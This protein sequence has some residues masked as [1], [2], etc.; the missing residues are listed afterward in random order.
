MTK[1]NRNKISQKFIWLV[2]F[3]LFGLLFIFKLPALAQDSIT[4]LNQ[5]ILDRKQTLSDLQ[6]Q[7]NAYQQ[8]IDQKIGEAKTLSN[9]LAIITNEVAKIELDIQASDQSIQTANLEIQSINIQIK[10]TENKIEIQ[11]QE[12]EKF[13]N[14]IYKNDQVSYLEILLAND[15]L[16]DFF[17]Y[18]KSTQQIQGSLK[19]TYDQ[20]KI[21]KT[22]LNGQLVDLEAKKVEE[23]NLRDQLLTQKSQLSEKS[24]AQVV[25]I[26]QTKMSQKQYEQYAYQLKLQQQQANSDITTL[27]KKIRAEAD[28]LKNLGSSSLDWPVNPA[29]G[30]TTY[31]HDPD[32]PFRYLFEHPGLDIRAAQGTSLKSPADAY[33]GKI[34][35]RGDT[36]YAYVLLIHADGIST[37]YG[38]ISKP[39]V[40]EGQY[41]KRGQA[42]A[43]SGGAPGSIGAGPLTTGPHL[44]LEVRVNGIPINPLKYLPTI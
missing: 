31:F 22:I 37:V 33:V 17:N 16:S 35:F 24:Q 20:L 36:S 12:I 4:N 18:F 14:L 21:G 30:I 13:L 3:F 25:L 5:E 19:N 15:S 44:H 43:L 2:I 6:K 27:E 9:Q 1:K 38:H 29:R 8:K 7:I 11:K 34:Q 42:F 40:S 39:L 41:I 32:Y 10:E 28:R 23:E 26:A